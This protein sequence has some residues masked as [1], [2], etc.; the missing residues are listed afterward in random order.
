MA[1]RVGL[2]ASTLQKIEQ[3]KFAMTEGVA[4]KISHEYLVDTEWLLRGKASDGIRGFSD[5]PWTKESVSAIRLRFGSQM[6]KPIRE[7]AVKHAELIMSKFAHVLEVSIADGNCW[8]VMIDAD[9]ALDEIVRTY[10]P[11][12]YEKWRSIELTFTP[13]KAEQPSRKPR[14]KA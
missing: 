12:I 14:R 6:P 1:K 3:G 11:Y 10:Y 7:Q 8:Q 13:P 5:L 2:G 9:I 4:R